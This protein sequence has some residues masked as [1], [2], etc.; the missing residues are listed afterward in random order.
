MKSPLNTFFE[1]VFVLNLPRRKDRKMQIIDE[2]KRYNIKYEFIDAVDGSALDIKNMMSLDNT[3]V[4]VGDIGCTRSHLAIA[5]LARLR[6]LKN[7]FVFEDDALLVS[8]FN[9]IFAHDIIQ[10]PSD[11]N[12]V[13]L[14]GN[15][16][17]SITKVTDNI[18]KMSRTFTTHAYGVQGGCINKIIEVLSLDSEK[19]DVAISTI[20]S[21]LPCYVLRPHIAFQRPSFS[22]I[23]N[24]FTDYK[25][26]HQ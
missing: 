22:D 15:H 19:V 23:L 1:Q 3:P 5:R 8:N 18:W 11:W 13:Y 26:L 20:H 10:L 14:G 4:S 24:T 17:G 16:D 2:L 25:H 12:M 7:Y 9:K 6:G 21:Q